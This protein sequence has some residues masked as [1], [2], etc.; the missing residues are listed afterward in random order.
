MQ[1]NTYAHCDGGELGSGSKAE[2]VGADGAGAAERMSRGLAAI[3]CD[4][5]AVK[6]RSTFHRL[7]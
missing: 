4:A 7:V 2:R 3:V 5:A 1:M 6:Y